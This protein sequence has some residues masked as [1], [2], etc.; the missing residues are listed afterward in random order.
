MFTQY[1]T[2]VE[3]PVMR[4]IPLRPCRERGPPVTSTPRPHA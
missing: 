4:F 3:M 2:R 1:G